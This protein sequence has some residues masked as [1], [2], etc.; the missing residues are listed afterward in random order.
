[1]RLHREEVRRI[2]VPAGA[3]NKTFFCKY[4]SN[5]KIKENLH[6][7]WDVGGNCDKGRGKG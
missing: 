3:Y 6:P 1:V 2:K 5:K 4:T 7:F